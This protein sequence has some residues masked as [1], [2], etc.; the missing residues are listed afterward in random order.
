MGKDTKPKD[1]PTLSRENHEDW[2]RRAGIK[3]RGKGVQFAI[4]SGR[5]EYAWIQR[6]G[7]VAGTGASRE[8]KQGVTQD[9]TPNTT[10][11]SGVD[12]LTSKFERMGGSWNIE[13]AEKWDQADAKALEIILDGLGP[14]DSIL[15][16]E[17]ETASAVWTQLKIKYNKTS[18]STANQ[19]LTALYNFSFDKD[20]GIDGSWTKLKEYRRKLVAANPTM[21]LAHPDE[22]LFLILT[23]ALQRQGSY[24]T[25]IDGFL[26][27]QSLSA[28]E[29]LKILGEKEAQLQGQS[30]RSE[31]ANAA[32]RQHKEVYRHPNHSSRRNSGSSD[33][34]MTGVSFE[35]YCCGSTDHYVAD[36][37][38][39][40]ASK[41]FAR[42][43]RLKEE[44]GEKEYKPRRTTERTKKHRSDR[45][46]YRSDKK[47]KKPSSGR[48]HGHAAAELS[49]S[50]NSDT[51]T[52]SSEDDSD[53]EPE[54]KQSRKA[55]KA[56]VMLT[57]EEISKST[58]ADWALDTG[59]S[60]PMTDQLHLYRKGTLRKYDV[61]IQVGEEGYTHGNVVQR[62]S[63]LVMERRAGWRM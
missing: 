32:W 57:K 39:Q 16:D 63:E 4:D 44:R 34:S 14:D 2:F 41:E 46:S 15:I 61:P 11:S 12:N 22:G 6:E 17:Y 5:T 26:T 18:A 43:L 58:P 54:P 7:G 21:R 33:M 31:K 47:S 55:V 38:F 13:R 30:G 3:I 53:T 40:A 62:G 37:K 10:D 42:N 28:D 60:S 59:A 51:E 1:L 50:T 20:T 56:N 27:Q 45:K 8:E 29:K 23:T 19:Y 9:A 52:E 48:K 24:T 36:C 25:E 49:E 35:C